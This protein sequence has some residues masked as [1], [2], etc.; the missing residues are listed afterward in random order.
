MLKSMGRV[1]NAQ[2]RGQLWFHGPKSALFIS[3]ADS[4]INRPMC[5][6][7]LYLRVVGRR[8][9]TSSWFRLGVHYA[10]DRDGEGKPRSDTRHTRH[11]VKQ[12]TA[13]GMLV[14]SVGGIERQFCSKTKY[15]GTNISSK[16]GG[17]RGRWPNAGEGKG[18]P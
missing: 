11:S 3:G 16:L 5:S 17:A 6:I 18:G 2:L 8:T 15:H 10:R 1:R 9:W 12:A 14:D 4:G 13:P 7:E